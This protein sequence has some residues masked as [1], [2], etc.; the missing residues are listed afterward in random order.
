VNHAHNDYLELLLEIGFAAV[1]AVAAVLYWV[2]AKAW[3][4]WTERHEPNAPLARAG[5][6]IGLML[7]LHSLVDYPLRTLALSCLF[8]LSCALMIPPRPAAVRRRVRRSGQPSDEAR[9]PQPPEAAYPPERIARRS[10][11]R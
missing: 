4:S 10:A 6:L 5:S 8:A 3:R 11:G 1:V 7:L 2:G 9:P